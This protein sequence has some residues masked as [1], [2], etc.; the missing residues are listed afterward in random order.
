[1]QIVTDSGTDFKIAAE[2]ASELNV[3]IVPLVVTLDGVSYHE[4]IDINPD[5]FYALLAASENMPVHHFDQA[6]VS[7]AHPFTP[8]AS[9]SIIASDLLLLNGKDLQ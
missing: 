4:G 3:T 9:R 6:V 5:E 2:N 8:P 7:Y 1:M